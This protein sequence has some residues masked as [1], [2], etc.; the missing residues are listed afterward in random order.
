MVDSGCQNSFPRMRFFIRRLNLHVGS[1][2]ERTM[3]RGGT[4]RSA[5]AHHDERYPSRRKGVHHVTS[6]LPPQPGDPD[7]TSSDDDDGE[8]ARVPETAEE[9]MAQV[10]SINVSVYLGSPVW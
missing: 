6:E 10:R 5:T 8:R 2:V 4:W 7:L 3:D 9:A 1:K